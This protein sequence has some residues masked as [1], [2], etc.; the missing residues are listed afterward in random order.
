MSSAHWDNAYV[1]KAVDER[2]WTQPS[3]KES[4]HHI[5]ESG[6]TKDAEIIDIGSGSS[7]LVDELL[8]SGFTHVSVLDISHSALVEVKER[9]TANGLDPTAVQWLCEDITSWTPQKKYKLW[10]DR[11]V[12]HFLTS[13]EEQHHYLK[14]VNAGT[15]SGS[16]IVM[17]TFA[18]TGPE[19][20]SGLP[21]TRWS[22]EKLQ[23]FF[24]EHYELVS[25]QLITHTTPWGSTQ[26][27]TWLHLKRK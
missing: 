4:L 19:S 15:E 20:C 17:G 2:S 24:G 3:P 22:V 8:T 25:G 7:T 12:F 13:P 11:A 21:V 27:F 26:D 9:L 18:P 10:H 16:H 6:V 23:Q 14:A 1:A 5:A